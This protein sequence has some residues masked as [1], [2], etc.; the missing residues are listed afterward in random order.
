[1]LVAQ[2]GEEVAAHLADLDPRRAA[3]IGAAARRRVLAEHTYEQRADYLDR[4]LDERT[5]CV[6]S[7]SAIR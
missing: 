2:S 6:S 4:L 3:A 1:V 5:A 7:G